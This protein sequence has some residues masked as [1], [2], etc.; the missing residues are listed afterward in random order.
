MVRPSVMAGFTFWSTTPPNDCTIGDG[1]PTRGTEG[2]VLANCDSARVVEP[3]AGGRVRSDAEILPS[4][5]EGSMIT[6]GGISLYPSLL[7]WTIKTPPPGRDSSCLYT[8]FD[9]GGWAVTPPVGFKAGG[10]T[11]GAGESVASYKR[12]IIS[13]V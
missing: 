8:S 13:A 11:P 5:S 6:P 10:V 1:E 12:E 7:P 2:P 3:V 9:A 4:P